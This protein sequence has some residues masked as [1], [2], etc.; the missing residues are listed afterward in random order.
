M[1]LLKN[2]HYNPINLYLSI[3]TRLKLLWSI[4][5]IKNCLKLIT[6]FGVQVINFRPE[7][8]FDFSFAKNKMINHIC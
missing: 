1:I 8:D 2:V 6:I 3:K 7:N 4:K 5:N